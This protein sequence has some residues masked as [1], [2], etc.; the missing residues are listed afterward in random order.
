MGGV[1]R[2][3]M[4]G[5]GLLAKPLYD[6]VKGPDEETLLWTNAPQTAFQTLKA[7]FLSAPAL[8]LP[9]LEKPFTLYVAEKQSQAL[10]VLTPKLGNEA[11]PVGYFSKSLDSV[12][13]G[14]PSCPRAVAATAFLVE[15]SK[16]TMGR[17]LTVMTLH[18]SSVLET[19]GRQW[20]TGGRRTE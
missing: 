8:G 10:G 15:A 16:L 18:R 4:P 6:S 5:F 12:A 20:M 3:W 19:K 2:L 14:W 13:P 1:C 17:S 9:N 7:K 11:R